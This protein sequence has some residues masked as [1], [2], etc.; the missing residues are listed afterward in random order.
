MA[1][2]ARDNYQHKTQSQAVINL[3]VE[4]DRL[5]MADPLFRHELAQWV[6][7]G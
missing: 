7:S 2:L 6:R 1:L 3:I 4:G 5:Q